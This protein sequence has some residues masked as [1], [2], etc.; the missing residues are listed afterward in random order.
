MMIVSHMHQ[1]IFIKTR[2]TAG[3]S[4]E[5]ILSRDC[6]PYDII[7]PIQKIDEDKRSKLGH[8]GPQN[9]KIRKFKFLN[10]LR[11]SLGF[12]LGLKLLEHYNHSPAK[13]IRKRINN[14][15]FD[16]YFK[17]CIVRNPW[18]RIVSEYYWLLNGPGKG[19]WPEGKTFSEFIQE[20]N[21]ALLSDSHIYMI[22]GKPAVDRFIKFEN[23]DIELNKCLK[24]LGITNIELPHAKSGTRKTKAHYSLLYD[25]TSLNKVNEI[26]AWEIDHFGYTFEDNRQ[27]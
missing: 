7:T 5:I 25:E 11:K 20:S 3:T 24:D 13:I 8:I 12:K 1:F 23:L 17:F 14:H 26:C 6:G 22:D 19:R 10:I 21:A 15:D 27:L 2:K 4:V 18:D 9:Y 16:N